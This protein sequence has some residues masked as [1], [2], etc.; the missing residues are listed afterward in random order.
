MWLRD[1][2][3]HLRVTEHHTFL[4]VEGDDLSVWTHIVMLKNGEPR[5]EGREFL[6]TIFILLFVLL[7][8]SL[9]DHMYMYAGIFVHSA[10]VLHVFFMFYAGLQPTARSMA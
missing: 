9:Y 7:L 6:T 8:A 3:S 10:V 4:S 1:V 5:K 2:E